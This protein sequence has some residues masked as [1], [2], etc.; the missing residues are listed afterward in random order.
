MVIESVWFAIGVSAAVKSTLVLAVAR[1]MTSALRGRSAA[2]RHLVWTAAAVAVLALP[3]FVVSLPA[4]RIPSLG[5]VAPGVAALFETTA[6]AGADAATP[7]TPVP[8]G[9]A[10]AQRPAH[11]PLDWRL[12]LLS[13]WAAGAAAAFAQMLFAFAAMS[14]VRRAARSSPDRTLAAELATQLGISRVVRIL[15]TSEG[16]MPMTF[17]VLRPAIFL[18]RDAAGWTEERRRVVLLHEL[19]HVRRGDVATHLI[20]RLALILNWCN[21]LAWV[22]WREFL[23]E[24]ERATDDLVLGCGAR[25]SEYAGHLLEV[26]R[27]MQPSPGLAWAAVAMAR[28]SQLEGRLVAI[29]DSKV[30][31]KAAGRASAWA[32]VLVAIALAAPF[33]AVRAQDP[34]STALPAD[35][36]ATIRAADAQKNHEMLEKPAEVFESRR[37]YDNAKKLLDAAVTIR[38]QES[39]S[40]SVAYGVGLMKLGDL[41]KKRN[42]PEEA[43]AFYSK[44]AALVGDRPEAAPALMYLGEHMLFNMNYLQAIEY[45]QKA[46]NLDPAQAGPAQMWMAVVREHEQNSAGAE[47]LFRSALAVEDANSADAATTMELYAFFL[48]D[49]GRGDEAAQ[50]SARA[51]AL[52]GA[53][54]REQLPVFRSGG[55]LTPASETQQLPGNVYRIGNGVTPP[56]LL[57][58]V[59]PEYTEEAR[60]AK[61]QGT[62]ALS[63]EIRPDGFA[64][65]IRVI[66]GLGLGLDQNAVNAV[67]QWQFQPGTKDGAPVP[68]QATIEVN[69]R[70]Q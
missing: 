16:S 49:Q 67:L 9:A 61:Y 3:F 60:A 26:A 30:N 18:P 53:T 10:N 5:T 24:R 62:A 12:L 33:A 19:A 46:K 48:K 64:D 52:R 45:F 31:R 40:Q 43:A 27:G 22:A 70:L 29:L 15:E 58:K 37:Q 59:E 11:G 20:A 2:L 56:K 28:R 6:T 65:N 68:V 38:E 41:E 17:G 21:P 50:M 42:R 25:A 55:R 39:G 23:K 66:K 4:L 13:L 32:A 54:P 35:I 57:S 8:S 14:R 44:A 63:V 34:A 51:A 36:D 1:L 7:R 69:F 47:S